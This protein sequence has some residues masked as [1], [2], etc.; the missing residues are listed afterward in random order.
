MKSI[1]PLAVAVM[2]ATAL[3]A[4]SAPSAN[5]L[6]GGGD[7]PKPA[8][9]T[10]TSAAAPSSAHPTYYGSKVSIP[11][12]GWALAHVDCPTGMVPTGGGGQTS[13]TATFITDSYPTSGGWSVGVKNTQ[14]LSNDAMAWVVCTTP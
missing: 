2:A 13:S 8:F 4:G 12:N 3:L 1:R 9:P 7:P 10:G 6:D 11:A 5:A 14:T